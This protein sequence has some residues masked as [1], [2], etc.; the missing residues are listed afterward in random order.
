MS[1]WSVG[2]LRCTDIY[3]GGPELLDLLRADA[4]LMAN[5]NAKTGIEEMGLLF[6]YLNAYRVTDKVTNQY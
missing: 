3:T 2:C 5:A 6:T 4:A 1:F